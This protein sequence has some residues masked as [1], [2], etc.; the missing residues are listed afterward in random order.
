MKNLLRKLLDTTQ[1]VENRRSIG[2]SNYIYA[3]AYIDLILLIKRNIK[4]FFLIAIGIFSATFGFKGFILT[5]HFIDGGATGIS[6][7]ISNTTPIPLHYIIVLINIPFVVLGYNIIGKH[8]A[9]KTS[10]AILGLA[11]CVANVEFP[12][13]TNNDI[14]VAILEDFF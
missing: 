11:L 12:N 3:K 5:N 4:D 9:I 14:L 1:L 8:F 7:L 6:L 13:V 2:A 10:L